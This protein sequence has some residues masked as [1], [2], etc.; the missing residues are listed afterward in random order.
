[1]FPLW[2]ERITAGAHCDKHI[3]AAIA[4][5]KGPQLNHSGQDLL[6]LNVGFISLNPCIFTQ[7]TLATNGSLL[8]WSSNRMAH[9]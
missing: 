9:H 8:E 3:K 1:M 7:K 5:S 2:R 4:S 6:L